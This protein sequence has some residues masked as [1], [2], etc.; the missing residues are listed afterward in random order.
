MK[1]LILSLSLFTM[2][3][4][5]A[6]N[7]KNIDQL[8]KSDLKNYKVEE[9][10]FKNLFFI[11]PKVSMTSKYAYLSTRDGLMNFRLVMEYNG[12]NWLYLK[13]VIIKFN[14]RQ[15]EYSAGEIT[16]DVGNGYVTETS[17]IKCSSEIV[18][19]LRE[20]NQAEKVYVRLEGST[21]V[22]DF[23]MSNQTKK[24]I[25]LALELYDKLKN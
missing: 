19:A 17:D 5:A 7:S 15:I 12:E 24:S 10:K 1:K 22:N 18:E 20:I 23:E 13:K 21:T 16:T 14:D 2:G 9:D 3:F 11:T 6:Q 8:E 25:R 4:L